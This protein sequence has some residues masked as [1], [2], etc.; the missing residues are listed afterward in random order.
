MPC[1]QLNPAQLLNDPVLCHKMVGCRINV[2]VSTSVAS[3]TGYFL[4]QDPENGTC[5]TLLVRKKGSGRNHI[6][7]VYT[8]I[9]TNM[10]FDEEDR[11]PEKEIRDHYA[12]KLAITA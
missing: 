1:V 10:T 11:L 3:V 8:S 9:I 6:L 12:D 2:K 4:Y 5:L 7:F